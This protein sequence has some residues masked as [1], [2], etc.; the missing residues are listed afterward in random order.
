MRL[1]LTAAEVLEWTGRLLS[2]YVVIDSLEKLSITKKYTDNDLFDWVRLRENHFFKR[3]PVLIRNILDV[4]FPAP[5]WMVLLIFRLLCGSY[6]LLFSLNTTVILCCLAGIFFIGSLMNL[7][8][9]AYGAESESRFSLVIAG[10]LVLQRIAPTHT[11]TIVAFWF[12]ALQACLSYITAGLSK[13]QNTNWRNGIG[14]QHIISSYSKVPL[15][16]IN[17]F[18]SRQLSIS[19]LLNWSVIVFECLFPLVLVIGRPYL[20]LFLACGVL[21]HASIAIWLRLGKFFWVW[22]A[23]Y[24]A[25][26]FIVQ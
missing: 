25:L 10:A 5:V 8:N 26:I 3:R 22:V 2:V 17:R 11:V 15:P 14:F 4:I 19:K 13:L 1:Y 18:F 21:F 20:W 23:T 9:I 24:P 7:R 6:L 12:I 16:A